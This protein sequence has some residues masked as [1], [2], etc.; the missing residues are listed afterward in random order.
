MRITRQVRISEENHRYL[1]GV[2]AVGGR[3]IS[4]L[5]DRACEAYRA[6]NGEPST[7]SA[8]S[9]LEAIKNAK[10]FLKGPSTEEVQ[11]ILKKI[12]AKKNPPIASKPFSV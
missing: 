9:A 6:A 1:K 4:K 12:H 7:L 2:S 10:E 8:D 5:V 3:T 11:R